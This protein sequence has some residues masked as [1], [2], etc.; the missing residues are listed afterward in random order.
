MSSETRQPHQEEDNAIPPLISFLEE[1]EGAPLPLLQ[2]LEEENA[3]E[4]SSGMEG[5]V[6]AHLQEGLQGHTSPVRQESIVL[7]SSLDLEQC[8]SVHL[9]ESGRAEDA[10][11]SSIARQESITFE[12]TY[13]AEDSSDTSPMSSPTFQSPY[14]NPE[15]QHQNESS[16]TQHTQS[17]EAKQM[18]CLL[19]QVEDSTQENDSVE[20]KPFILDQPLGS[21][22]TDISHL[23]PTAEGDSPPSDSPERSPSPTTGLQ[24]PVFVEGSDALQ[25]EGGSS[26]G[27]DDE[28]EGYPDGTQ[29]LGYGPPYEQQT[30]QVAANDPYSF[31]NQYQ[32]DAQYQ[33]QGDMQSWGSYNQA[34]AQQT[35]QQLPP[36]PPPPPPPPERVFFPPELAVSPL[37]KNITVCGG[38]PA[39]PYRP[40][41]EGDPNLTVHAIHTVGGM[42][43]NKGPFPFDADTSI[44]K[45]CEDKYASWERH[46]EERK[47]EAVLAPGVPSLAIVN[48]LIGEACKRE[49][50]YVRRK[51]ALRAE[52]ERAFRDQEAKTSLRSARSNSDGDEHMMTA[53]TEVSSPDTAEGE[54]ACVGY[55]EGEE[56]GEGKGA[57]GGAGAGGVY[58]NTAEDEHMLSYYSRL[59]DIGDVPQDVLEQGMQK[60]VND[61]RDSRS[62]GNYT[63]PTTG[64]YIVG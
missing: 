47:R 42:V 45:F 44:H 56:G 17:K 32:G 60:K 33:Q 57:G 34:G 24:S 48:L 29:F 46:C 64:D 38:G 54:E 11:N 21:S 28:D 1:E 49:L 3:K 26:D 14:I 10:I 36:P 4:G 12:R 35:Y 51:V 27:S 5:A 2:Y 6:H 58:S 62:C 50:Q 19:R 55:T 7:E 52:R 40:E 9:N 39:V 63:V 61:F 18:Q 31:S 16:Q 25:N 59:S 20:K 53:E 8:D 43:A 23:I 30:Q 41:I 22:L 15:M 13:S 37:C